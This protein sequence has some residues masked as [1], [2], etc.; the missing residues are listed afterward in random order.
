[1]WTGLGAA[2]TAHGLWAQDPAQLRAWESGSN[3]SSCHG[4]LSPL[5]L[6]CRGPAQPGP[7]WRGFLLPTLC[8]LDPI[9]SLGQDTAQKP[10]LLLRS[11]LREAQT[12]ANPGH[13][14]SQHRALF[15]SWHF[16]SKASAWHLS[17]CF[18]ASSMRAGTISVCS[19]QHPKQLGEC[20]AQSRHEQMLTG[21]IHA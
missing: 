21:C 19:P 9:Y 7:L 5:S 6:G 11:H 8:S 20:P 18:N 1:M 2:S 17:P 14:S 10:F 15:S 12:Q 13:P 4:L 3:L 16:L